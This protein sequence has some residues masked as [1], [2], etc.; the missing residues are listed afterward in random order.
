MDSGQIAGA[1][2]FCFPFDVSMSMSLCLHMSPC[3]HFSTFPCLCLQV[4]MSPSLHVSKSPSLHVSMSPCFSK[5][6]TATSVCFCKRKTET[7][8][9]RLFAANEKG[10]RKF[11]FFG[12]QT[13]NGNRRLLFQQKFMC[14]CTGFL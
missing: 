12:Q 10:K 13:I 1:S 2:V 4:S 5:R 9:I 14:I 8:N 3:L 6:K 11:G 7:A